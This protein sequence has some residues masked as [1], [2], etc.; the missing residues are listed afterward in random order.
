MRIL[1]LLSEGHDFALGKL[2]ELESVACELRDSKICPD[3]LDRLD[4]AIGFFH[5]EVEEHFK[6]EEMVLFPVMEKIIG[7]AG[8]IHAMLEEHR[9]FWR[10]IETLEERLEDVKGDARTPEL[11]SLEQVVTHIV[12]FLRSHITKE[13]K[14]FFPLAEQSLDPL[15]VQETE[16]LLEQLHH[17]STVKSLQ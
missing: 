11:R 1:R 9:S 16:R 12:A 3:T 2:S 15:S 17:N 7:R 10:A 13:E 6:Q 14:S 8:F 5:K 4:K